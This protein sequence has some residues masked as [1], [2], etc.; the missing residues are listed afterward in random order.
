MYDV[1]KNAT[2]TISATSSTNSADGFL[3]PRNFRDLETFRLATSVNA[4]D[5]PYIYWSPANPEISGVN[6]LD[7]RGWCL[8][9][10]LLSQRILHFT[11]IQVVFECA[12]DMAWE[13][14]PYPGDFV[15]VV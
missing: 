3:S 8:Q 13:S 2:F 15:V 10:Q 1:C 7:T 4:P 12:T 6:H 9:E 11:N 5:Y 14:G